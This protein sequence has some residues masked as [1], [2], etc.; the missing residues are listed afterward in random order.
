[1]NS[2]NSAKVQQQQQQRLRPNPLP[3]RQQNAKRQTNFAVML[4]VETYL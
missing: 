1:M 3:R 4:K 2:P